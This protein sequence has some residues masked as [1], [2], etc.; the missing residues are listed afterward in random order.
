MTLRTSAKC[1]AGNVEP[2]RKFAQDS[3]EVLLVQQ[4]RLPWMGSSEIVLA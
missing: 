2:G 4:Q 3:V 1:C